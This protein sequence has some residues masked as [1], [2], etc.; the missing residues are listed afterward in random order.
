MSLLSLGFC[1]TPLLQLRGIRFLLLLLMCLLGICLA[2][3][4]VS[5][6]VS[7]FASTSSD[8]IVVIWEMVVEPTAD[9]KMID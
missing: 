2:G 6:R 5:D 9:G 3:R 7:I 4:M 1:L 8:G